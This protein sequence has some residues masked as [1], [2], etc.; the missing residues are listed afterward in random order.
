MYILYMYIQFNEHTNFKFF[1][2]DQSILYISTNNII[3]Y[4]N[5]CL[6]DWVWLIACM[7]N[8]YL[9]TSLMLLMSCWSSSGWLIRKAQHTGFLPSSYKYETKYFEQVVS[10]L[11]KFETILTTPSP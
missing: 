7:M 4:E 3:L 2:A 11:F 8:K 6:I 1:N 5:N 9:T 10:C